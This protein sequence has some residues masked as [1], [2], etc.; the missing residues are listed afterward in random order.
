MSKKN[1]LSSLKTASKMKAKQPPKLISTIKKK[2]R[3]DVSVRK[4]FKE[5]L[6][7]IRA[8]DPDDV[9]NL[10]EVYTD[11]FV[12]ERGA[13]SSRREFFER[14]ELIPSG[15]LADFLAS[16]L[17]NDSRS[18]NE[19]LDIFF[20]TKD[21][22]D[23]FAQ[24]DEESEE[25]IAATKK[26]AM[27]YSKQKQKT[28][29]APKYSKM[30]SM[31]GEDSEEED[32]D[33]EFD[34]DE[35]NDLFDKE[36]E[37]E[38][39]DEEGDENIYRLYGTIEEQ[40]ETLRSL[41]S[42]DAK[43]KAL[44]TAGALATD[45]LS[46]LPTSE[47]EEL[48]RKYRKYYQI[49]EMSTMKKDR[50][51]ILIHIPLEDENKLDIVNKLSDKELANIMRKLP[52][53]EK[54]EFYSDI[55]PDASGT[56]K[57]RADAFTDLPRSV[58][59]GVFAD[60]SD[61]RKLMIID[62][63]TYKDLVDSIGQKRADALS[64]S[65][66]VVAGRNLYLTTDSEE[67]DKLL[68]YILSDQTIT[69]ENE[70][71][72]AA[73]KAFQ[74]LLGALIVEER[75]KNKMPPQL[76]NGNPVRVITPSGDTLRVKTM[77]DTP[78][79]SKVGYSKDKAE[80]YR[81]P[82]WI[83]ARVNKVY[84]LPRS[85]N[86]ANLHDKEP[87]TIDGEKWYRAKAE[88]FELLQDNGS[89][90][91]VQ[92]CDT[93][94]IFMGDGSTISF[95]LGFDTNRGFIRQDEDMYEKEKSYFRKQRMTRAEELNALGLEVVS[96]T[97][98]EF[99]RKLLSSVLLKVAPKCPEYAA[100]SEYV[101]SAISI[102]ASKSN[103]VKEFATSLGEICVMLNPKDRSH[104]GLPIGDSSI[105]VA[106]VA[107]QYYDPDMLVM[108]DMVTRAPEVYDAGLS[109]SDLKKYE[110]VFKTLVRNFVNMFIYE[111]YNARK[112][113]AIK[114]PEQKVD[115]LDLSLLCVNANSDYVKNVPKENIVYYPENGKVYCFPVFDIVDRIRNG[116]TTN[117]ITG[118]ELD[119]S[120][121]KEW[122]VPVAAQRDKQTPQTRPKLVLAP[123]LIDLAISRI[124]L[125][126]K[127]LEQQD[128]V[129]DDIGND[130]GSDVGSDVGSDAG[131][132][133]G[134]DVSYT[135]HDI[136]VNKDKPTNTT[137]NI[138]NIPDSWEDIVSDDELE[139]TEVTM[140]FRPKG[141]SNDIQ[142]K[143]SRQQLLK[144]DSTPSVSNKS[145]TRMRTL[146]KKSGKF[147]ERD[148]G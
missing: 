27:K 26:E 123:G 126:K 48:R 23:V 60:H 95:S 37:E 91:R 116:D 113:T 115:V 140:S 24:R 148:F 85:D 103:N 141:V 99:G 98:K 49:P 129:Q 36:M 72:Y 45:I 15:L 125:L 134:S 139:P 79:I 133:A 92:D 147:V 4:F 69:R 47:A 19:S 87:V 46:Q 6:D 62:S 112:Y 143:R 42:M 13:P 146:V 117:P 111:V 119:E 3:E 102:L 83:N 61:G 63:L 9:P 68:P 73:N 21:M 41:K 105:Y 77:Y 57:D 55:N 96:D 89:R 52:N 44:Y 142:R 70:T 78:V 109:K 2:E 82:P 53:V 30:E 120:F 137:K 31:F 108:G 1:P 75:K 131:S 136:S 114:P 67:Y 81:R 17:S 74:T 28:K 35:F 104:F 11:Q 40:A 130:A 101:H 64:G 56:I 32:S 65:T 71:W 138:D 16:H 84:V 10:I 135:V 7:T 90:K 106:R 80:L 38:D 107:A 59:A 34:E 18:A 144:T 54:A 76:G 66:N 43:L 50:E 122:T 33:G 51:R 25:M 58:L 100:R 39:E 110:D 132:D 128:Y 93:L 145:N 88:L 29:S 118:I 14:V 22:R 12:S 8:S 127:Q 20:R 124:S 121:V 5:L 86:T 97:V 94:T